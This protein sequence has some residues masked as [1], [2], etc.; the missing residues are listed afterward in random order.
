[1]IGQILVEEGLLRQSELEEALEVQRT[2]GRR[3]GNILTE[4]GFV[5]ED[6]L[7]QTL[8]RQFDI[9]FFDLVDYVIDPVVVTLIPEHLCERY[10]LIP[11]MKHGE[12]LIVAFSDPVNQDAISDIHTLTGLKI[13][14]VVST[15]SAINRALAAAFDALAVREHSVRR[16]WGATVHTSPSTSRVKPRLRK[17]P[18]S[19]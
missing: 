18:R 17:V 14:I 11:I 6:A 7:A 9:P 3:L 1:M 16:V 19:R 10:R 13:R 4:K 5:T 2:T 15:P 8:A 12:R